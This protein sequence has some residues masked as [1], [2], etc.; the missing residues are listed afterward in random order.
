MTTSCYRA[1][2]ITEDP[3]GQVLNAIEILEVDVEKK[4][5]L[6]QLVNSHHWIDNTVVCTREMDTTA[7][8]DSHLLR[9]NVNFLFRSGGSSFM[10]FLVPRGTPKVVRT[11]FGRNSL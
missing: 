9:G 6:S 11:C 1:S 10:S 8:I 2:C 4:L 5:P 3:D 7:A